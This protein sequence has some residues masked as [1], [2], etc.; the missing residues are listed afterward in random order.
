MVTCVK[1]I[2]KNNTMSTTEEWKYTPLI[3]SIR[4]EWLASR[5]NY[6]TVGEELQYL[7][8]PEQ[9]RMLWRREKSLVPAWDQI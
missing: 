9:V 7:M 2:P 5:L 8:V 6:F 3:L 1:L 4:Y